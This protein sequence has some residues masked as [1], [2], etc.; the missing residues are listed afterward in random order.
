MIVCHLVSLHEQFFRVLSKYFWADGSAP[1]PQKN[2]PVRLCLCA[3]HLETVAVFHRRLYIACVAMATASAA[4][5]EFLLPWSV[6]QCFLLCESGY[7]SFPI[8]MSRLYILLLECYCKIKE[9]KCF[10]SHITTH[11][12]VVVHLLVGM[13]RLFKKA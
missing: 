6:I 13:G 1:P 4:L 12:V 8:K 11:R 7:T 2:W 3:C 10:G 5:A 9:L